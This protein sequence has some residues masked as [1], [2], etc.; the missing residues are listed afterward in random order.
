MTSTFEHT[1][2]AGPF[3][4][5]RTSE[6]A[7]FRRLVRTGD[8]SALRD[9]IL[10]LH[11]WEAARR[12]QILDDEH[13]WQ[14]LQRMPPYAGAGV[15][16]HL[17][18]HRQVRLARTRPAREVAE[19][20]RRMPIDDRVDVL[21]GVDNPRRR[22]LLAHFPEE[23]RN[24]TQELASYP[25]ET[26]GSIMI[27]Q[28]VAVTDSATVG[29][30]VEQ[31]RLGVRGKEPMHTVYVTDGT[32]TLVGHLPVSD[33]L[34]TEVTRP[35]ASVMRTGT[36]TVRA[37]EDRGD[38]ARKVQGFDLLEVPVVDGDG[39]LI[40]V[41]TVDDVI[42]VLEEDTSDT[43]YQKAGVGDLTHQRD[44]VFSERLTQGGVG[45]AIRV[46]IGYLL[47][48]LAG[49][50]AVGGLID[51]WEDTLAA[52]L[53]AAV[54]IPVIMD[55]GGNT[56]TQSTTIF[57]RGLALGH[58]DLR[59]FLPYFLREASIGVIMGAILGTIG[60]TIAYL[61]QGAPNGV[62]QLGIAVGFSLFAVVTVAAMLGFL[63]PYILVKVG[64]DHAPGADP[65]ITTIKD[66]TGLALYF[67]LVSRLIAVDRE[68]EEVAA[69]LTQV[70]P[71]VVLRG[72]TGLG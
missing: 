13:L 52:V 28:F 33:L 45:Y 36:V 16:S 39:R 69:L 65:F 14:V 5:P 25:D 26:V 71:T 51:F 2:G 58:I 17:P 54:F 53:A 68:G 12:L 43:M 61:W 42:D 30:A 6:A 47:V 63:L 44:H 9:A 60:G 35:I 46:R 38:A 40:G 15:L 62:P 72:W 37:D 32:G 24:Q 66:F 56:G 31:I 22:E 21:Q 18:I 4:N 57:A 59:R 8:I 29:D 64:L 50:M 20:L 11:H 1:S 70:D 48:A 49:G 19:L 27:P 67:L 10:P 23:E 55:M 34:T 41:V 7:E 3:G